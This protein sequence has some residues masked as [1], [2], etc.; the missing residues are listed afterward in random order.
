MTAIRRFLTG[1]AETSDHAEQTDFK[2]RYYRA[3]QQQVV[4]TVSGI[5][6][7]YPGFRIVHLDRERGEVTLEV[8]NSLGLI[9]DVVVTATRMTPV[10][11]AVD[12]HAALRA[13]LFDPG[14][15]RRII[16]AIWM[17]LD[18]RLLRGTGG[19]VRA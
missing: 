3:N 2:T 10:S 12:I 17:H 15:N 4:E 19:T 18:D 7:R 11:T 5:V 16:R 14:W 13:G 1:V 8:R 9:H 6:G